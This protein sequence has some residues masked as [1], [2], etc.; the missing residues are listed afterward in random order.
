[1]T[2]RSHP[3]QS[4]GVHSGPCIECANPHADPYSGLCER[5]LFGPMDPA[6]YDCCRGVDDVCVATG[7]QMGIVG[8]ERG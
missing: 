1:M 5:C 2:D 8:A 3:S 6:N 4:D 7:C